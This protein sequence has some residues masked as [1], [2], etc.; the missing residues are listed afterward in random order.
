MPEDREDNPGGGAGAGP[1][2]GTTGTVVQ[3]GTQAVGGTGG[4]APQGTTESTGDEGQVGQS[5]EERLAYLQPRYDTTARELKEAKARLA[6]YETR[7]PNRGM[8]TG[9]PTQPP[10]NGTQGHDVWSNPAM[11]G[12]RTFLNQAYNQSLVDGDAIAYETAK[13]RVVAQY[14]QLAPHLGMG[15]GQ[16]GLTA[17]QVRAMVRE[18]GTRLL[19]EAESRGR[20]FIGSIGEVRKEFG[21]AYIDGRI[22]Y[23]GHKMTREDAVEAW[24]NQTGNNSVRAGLIAVDE[25]GFVKALEERA[26]AV[27]TER[28]R[29]GQQGG[30]PSGYPTPAP[31]AKPTPRGVQNVQR[32]GFP[33]E[34]A[35]ARFKK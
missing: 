19:T 11:Q 28:L 3:P 20:Q 2:G 7:T 1:E 26:V 5:P 15:G 33:T 18:E 27:A 16:P 9:T 35:G 14:P 30:Q 29:L 21:N 25:G 12:I 34:P 22:N 4:A 8:E 32:A 13:A 23:N 17:D 10:Q 31:E 24:M 6:D